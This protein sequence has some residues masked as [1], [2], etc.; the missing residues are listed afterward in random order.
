VLKLL[1]PVLLHGVTTHETV[2]WKAY[3][4]FVFSVLVYITD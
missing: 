2:R 3:Y 4:T 1:T